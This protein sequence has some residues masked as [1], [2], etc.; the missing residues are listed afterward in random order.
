[1]V[2]AHNL[3]LGFRHGYHERIPARWHGSGRYRIA[4]D[5][6]PTPVTY[7]QHRDDKFYSIGDF[8]ATVVEQAPPGYIYPPPADPNHVFIQAF[9][10]KGWNVNG[11]TLTC[12]FQ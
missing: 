3:Q 4:Y 2:N 1:M 7:D 9:A 11:H 8:V 10:D 6:L 12:H 5:P